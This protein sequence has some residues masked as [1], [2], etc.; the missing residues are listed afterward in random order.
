MIRAYNVKRRIMVAGHCGDLYRHVGDAQ[1]VRQAA[2]IV[3][4]IERG[5]L[6]ADALREEETR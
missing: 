4:A 5:M 1:T 2:R 6:P 3:R